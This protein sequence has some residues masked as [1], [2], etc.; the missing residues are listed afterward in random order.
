M[1]K[2]LKRNVKIKQIL[3]LIFSELELYGGLLFLI[4]GLFFT[5]YM[6]PIT[7]FDS[8]TFEKELLET[9][10]KLTK[11]QEVNYSESDN[12]FFEYRY[13]FY[14]NEKKYNGK[15]YDTFVGY[16]NIDSIV[17]VEYQKYNPQKSR[18]KNMRMAPSGVGVFIFVLLFPIIG[19]ISTL[20]YLKKIIS[21]LKYVKYGYLSN[22]IIISKKKIIPEDS[23]S[24][25]TYNIE[26]QY[27]TI[28]K[29]TINSII[30]LRVDEIDWDEIYVVIIY[31][32]WKPSDAIPLRQI[33]SSVR[34]FIINTPI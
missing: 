4:V 19:L 17:R 34:D 12:T 20:I 28:E 32:P 6:Y 8:I 5:F 30:S 33:P 27:L 26:I 14:V 31:L 13:D 11:I 21:N 23:E 16:E 7:D 1:N 15:S 25:T 24:I 18:I 10:G 22:A 29:L 9:K 3:T 2:T